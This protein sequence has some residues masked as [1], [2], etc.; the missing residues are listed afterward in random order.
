MP[1]PAPVAPLYVYVDEQ[2]RQ[3]YKHRFPNRPD[4][5][6]G[7][8]LRVKK[9]L[10]GHPESPRLWAKLI[11]HIIRA[12]NLRPCTHEPNLYFTDDYNG[13]GK[14]VLFMKQVDDFCVSC[15][16]RD[17]AKNV[18]AAINDKMTIDV[19]EL[20]LISRFNGVDVTQTR[21]YIK[22]SNAVYIE[23]ILR[24]HPWILKEHPPA[25]FP[26]PMRSD[27]TYVRSLET[28]TPFTDEERQRYESH[29]GFTYRQGIGEVI[30][31]LVTCR[32]DIS[33]AAIKLSQYSTA[34]ARVHFDA[35]QDIFPYLKAT[36]DDGIYFW[37]KTPRDDLPIGPKPECKQDANY[38]ETEVPTRQETDV[39]KLGG[40]VDSDHAGDVSH[41]KSVTG[42]VVK[43]A[44]GAVL[45]KTAYQQSLAHSSTELEFV[46]ACDAGKYILY[47]RSLLE[48]IGLPQ[49]E[50]TVLYEDNQGALLMANAQRPTKRTRHM[51]L[52]YFGLQEW[53]ERDLLVLRRINTADN[54][55]DALTKALGRTL[56]YRH[57]NFIMGQITP[58]YAYDAM[59]LS[60]RRFF[61][62]TI[63]RADRKL[64]FLSRE[65]VT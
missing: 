19:K 16:D 9:A 45:Y 13:T 55:A 61:D 23:K 29:L 35:L 47:L 27:N 53:V 59:D 63:S 5:P 58:M 65:G 56:F 49:H 24:N 28:A 3:W 60:V 46:A 15:E 2:F 12:L 48:E 52:K 7:F 30:Y 33:F 34:P 40:A 50:A 26:L 6:P 44:G 20:G 8:V 22:L 32:P 10:Q 38:N 57:M 18:I 51:D 62:S 25:L 31:A 41:R 37:R 54:Y 39:R 42:V 1:S 4:I 36:K 64:R 21:H 14:M 11:D 43:L 17:T